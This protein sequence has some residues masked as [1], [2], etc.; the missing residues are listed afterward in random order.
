LDAPTAVDRGLLL[1]DRRGGAIL[2][3]AL[4]F[5]LALLDVGNAAATFWAEG[6]EPAAGAMF[7]E[8]ALSDLLSSE[9]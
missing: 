6:E 4:T 5:V 2:L 9:L 1:P 7:A 8:I 3:L